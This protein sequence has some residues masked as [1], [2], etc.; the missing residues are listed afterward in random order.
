MKI[1]EMTTRFL[2]GS[3]VVIALTMLVIGG[4]VHAAPL[5]IEAEDYST[6]ATSKLDLM[7]TTPDCA[8]HLASPT[9][10]SGMYFTVMG[11]AQGFVNFWSLRN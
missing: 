11:T 4:F 8:V 2:S 5:Q 7:R 9:N 10:S 1:T 6:W 3:V